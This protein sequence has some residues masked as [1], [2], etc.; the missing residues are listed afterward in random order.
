MADTIYSLA[1]AIAFGCAGLGLL[2]G[3]A[4]RLGP[5]RVR[6]ARG[7][8]PEGEAGRGARGFA[9][10]SEDGDGTDSRGARGVG[11]VGFRGARGVVFG[12]AGRLGRVAAWLALCALA[13]S[14]GVH[15][16]FAEHGVGLWGFFA[17]HPAFLVAAG[18]AGLALG[19]CRRSSPRAG[20]RLSDP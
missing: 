3:I 7:L 12:R 2:L 14:I 19:L 16:L 10:A 5:H 4:H 18:L 8:V 6:G 17:L 15:A 13:T 1:L 9:V 11:G 20:R